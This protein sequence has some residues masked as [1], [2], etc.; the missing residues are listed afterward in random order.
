MEAG[1]Q[2]KGTASPVSGWNTSCLV[3]PEELVQ[4]QLDI[5]DAAFD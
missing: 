4:S 3:W 1:R 2:Q 5:A